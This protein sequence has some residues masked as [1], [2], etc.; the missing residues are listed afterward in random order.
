MKYNSK[1]S[2]R[3]TI[4]RDPTRTINVGGGEAFTLSPK[5]E[6]YERVLTCLMEPK[7]YDP[8]GKDTQ[9]AIASL[10]AQLAQEDPKYV[11]QLANYARNAMY[12]RSVPLFLL[13]HA[14]KYPAT[15]QYIREYAPKI[16]RRADELTEATALW[17]QE[18]GDIGNHAKT[19]MMCNALKDGIGEAFRN[20][21][22]YQFAK[23]NRD[24][25]VKLR[26]VLRIAR[27]KPA[28]AEQ[29]ALWGKIINDTL[30]IP[31]TW[32][33]YISKHGSSKRTWEHIMPKMPIMATLRNLRNFAKVGAD[34]TPVIK[35]LEDPN[36]IARSKQ[37]PF[38]FFS[39]YRALEDS[40]YTPQ[41][42]RLMDAVQ[43]A[44]ALSV[45]NIPKIPGYTAMSADNSGS[46]GTRLS[47]KSSV[48][49]SD[50]ANL[51]QA[52]AQYIC[53]YSMTSVFGTNY[54]T[55]NVSKHSS[56]LDNMQKFKN[57]HTGSSTFGYKFVEDLLNRK[58]FVD[59]MLIF[60]DC[61]LYNEHGGYY[62]WSSHRPSD[63]IAT[64]FAKYKTQVNPKVQ[65]YLFN[66]AG[67]GTVVV[68]ERQVNLISGWSEKV[69]KF[70]ELNESDHADM[71]S[72]IAAY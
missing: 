27:P 52:I 31:D 1:P 47:P 25:E 67:Y 2:I 10:V 36:I 17:I 4:Q 71:L 23:Y 61:Q 6:L 12:L 55:V 46:M 7:F 19:G 57:T 72:E 24:G 21:D 59:R 22:E 51:L 54:Y 60:T 15:R 69:L 16:I 43:T 30:R 62:S 65:L 50:I 45:R 39:A 70:I 8:S 64:L 56:I 5:K 11:L 40:D 28:N 37:F 38:R 49:Y 13:I 41:T 26:D 29:A 42:S 20:F 63:T 48:T 35:K 58:I 44:M 14:C 32:E 68:P 34:I 53:E 3:R 9:H 18:N 66:L 33:T